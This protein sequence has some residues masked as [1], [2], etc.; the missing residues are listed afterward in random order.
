MRAHL[1]E[2]ASPF[3]C[4]FA[5]GGMP[6]RRPHVLPHHRRW[7][8]IDSTRHE[9][10]AG[11][12]PAA[13]ERTAECTPGARGTPRAVDGARHSVDLTTAAAHAAGHVR[14]LRGASTS[15]LTDA[16]SAMP[17]LHAT[18]GIILVICASVASLHA[19]RTH[20]RGN[21]AGRCDSRASPD[22]G[23]QKVQRESENLYFHTLVA[24]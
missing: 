4:P 15:S 24:R 17:S 20:I 23:S 1:G 7:R 10:I 22:S 13:P 6:L 18:P 19:P 12:G 8:A 5:G 21:F 16:F 2:E 14:Q 9:H 11:H 3:S